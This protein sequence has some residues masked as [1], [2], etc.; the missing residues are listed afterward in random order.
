M[1]PAAEIAVLFVVIAIVMGLL[2]LVA[3]LVH[4]RAGARA[5][6]RAANPPPVTPEEPPGAPAAASLPEPATDPATES[7]PPPAAE[8]PPVTPD[9]DPASPAAATPAPPPVSAVP[10]PDAPTPPA[11]ASDR[12]RRT[13]S[14]SD[15]P[16]PLPEHSRQRY[17][18]AWTGV[19]H[20]FE[21]SPVLALSQADALLG[22]LLAERGLPSDGMRTQADLPSGAGGKLLEEFRLGHLI[23]QSNSTRRAD[24][25]QVSV[26]M[27]HFRRV[28]EELVRDPGQASPSSSSASTAS[29]RPR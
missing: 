3:L 29:D 16:T 18:T 26:G 27:E 6:D 5:A 20:R 1:M 22:A 14:S 10:A 23:E 8:Q 7:A 21:D 11:P 13:A 2:G 28:F 9:A 4:R 15:L 12:R 24:L 17:L 19:Q 25:A